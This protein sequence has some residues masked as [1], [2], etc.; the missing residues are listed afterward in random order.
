MRRIGSV[1]DFA[2]RNGLSAGLGDGLAEELAPVGKVEEE[3]VVG[4]EVQW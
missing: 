3:V 1:V 2:G 4:T